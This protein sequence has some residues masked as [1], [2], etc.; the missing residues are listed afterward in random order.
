MRIALVDDHHLIMEMLRDFCGIHLGHEIVGEAADGLDA[1]AM[2]RRTLPE[3]VLLDLDLPR[4]SGFDVITAIAGEHI[5]TRVMVLSGYCDDRTVYRLERAGVS[6][7][8]DK[9]ACTLGVLSE[10]LDVLRAGHAYFSA[11]FR[12]VQ[13]RRRLDPQAC[14]KIISPAEMRVL[15]LTAELRTDDQIAAALGVTRATVEKHRLNL[16]RKL[17]LSSRIELLRYAR[18][19]GLMHWQSG[20]PAK[21]SA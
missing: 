13:L 20:H 11:S 21:P 7:F 8:I 15:A 3:V 6:G 18:H 10:A 5:A 16:T 2:L 12:E 1:I 19:C 4:L 17:N 14:E 9:S